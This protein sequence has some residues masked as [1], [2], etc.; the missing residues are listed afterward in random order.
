MHVADGTARC[1]Q[2][3]DAVIRDVASGNHGG[4]RRFARP[5]SRDTL[6]EVCR[7]YLQH[8]AT[9]DR[10]GHEPTFEDMAR[11]WNGGPDGWKK[12]ETLNYWRKVKAEIFSINN[13]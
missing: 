3:T 12:P 11:I 2:I 5:L 1:L 8:W 6:I 10:L 4:V 7:L 13:L 9:P